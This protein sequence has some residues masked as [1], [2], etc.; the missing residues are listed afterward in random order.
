MGLLLGGMGVEP[1]SWDSDGRT[2]LL[3][4]TRSEWEKDGIVKLLLEQE[5]VDPGLPNND[6]RTLLSFPAEEGVRSVVKLLLECG[7]V[8]PNLGD[9]YGRTPLSFDAR[10]GHRCRQATSTTKGYL[11]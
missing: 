11:P 2:P 1:D 3:Y 8:G 10:G 5:G 6:G 4:G 9:V 7:G